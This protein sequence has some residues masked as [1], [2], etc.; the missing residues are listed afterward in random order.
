MIATSLAGVGLVHDEPA[1]LTITNGELTEAT[2]ATLALELDGQWWT[3]PVESGCLPGVER[4][5]LLD[6]GV[7][8]ERVLRREDLY[9]AAGLAVTSSL[10]GW[11]AAE[12]REQSPAGSVAAERPMLQVADWLAPGSRSRS[13]V[14][15]LAAPGHEVRS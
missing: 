7:L 6:L 4:A 3:P 15:G 12:L 2:R 14:S 10:H 11:R 5:R 8:R 13:A 9:R 1:H